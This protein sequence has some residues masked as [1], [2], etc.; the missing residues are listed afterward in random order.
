MMANLTNDIQVAEQALMR[1]V[2]EVEVDAYSLP[3][4]IN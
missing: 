1:I 3:D 2:I 4:N